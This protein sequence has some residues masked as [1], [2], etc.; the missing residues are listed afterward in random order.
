MAG[1]KVFLVHLRRPRRDPKETRKDPFYEFGSFGC[2]RCHWHN[3]LNPR[4]ADELDGARLAFVQGG[5]DGSRLLLLT[6]PVKVR[7]WRDRCEALWTPVDMPFKYGTAPILAKND[8]DGDFDL[9]EKW[10]RDTDRSTVEGGLS[11]RIRSRVKPLEP[12]LARELVKVYADRREKAR[13]SEIAKAYHEALPYPLPPKFKIDCDRKATYDKLIRALA[14]SSSGRV[15]ACSPRRTIRC[16][17]T[18]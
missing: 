12:I 1:P 8:G 11:S 13:P 16:A 5:P 9:I 18:D 3:L 14:R 6:P 7:Q 2:T 17:T 10:A 15:P 4:H